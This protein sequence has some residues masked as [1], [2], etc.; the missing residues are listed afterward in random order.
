MKLLTATEIGRKLGQDAATVN[1]MLKTEKFLTEAGELTETGRF[2]G[3]MYTGARPDG[4]VYRY[5]RWN[6]GI[7][8]KIAKTRVAQSAVSLSTIDRDLRGLVEELRD[9]LTAVE[10]RH[11]AAV[12]AL[13]AELAELK[14]LVRGEDL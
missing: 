3:Q 4:T 7:V 12:E 10:M 13:Q 14:R 2:Y 9:E 6:A 11:D 8:E 5:A 1:R